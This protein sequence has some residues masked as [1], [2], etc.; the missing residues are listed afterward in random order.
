MLYSEISWA[1]EYNIR[2]RQEWVFF[3]ISYQE[4]IILFSS[5]LIDK[6]YEI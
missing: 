3:Y 1:K 4:L 2:L 5:A 6:Q